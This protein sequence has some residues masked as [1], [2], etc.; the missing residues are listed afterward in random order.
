MSDFLAGIIS[1]R[2]IVSGAKTQ[3]SASL[4]A[5][6]SLGAVAGANPST[7]VPPGTGTGNVAGSNAPT[8]EWD[9]LYNDLATEDNAKWEMGD[10]NG[11]VSV[12]DTNELS[13]DWDLTLERTEDG[14][15]PVESSYQ[16]ETFGFTLEDDKWL[17]EDYQPRPDEQTWLAEHGDASINIIE[18]SVG[19]EGSV[20]HGEWGS[21][22]N[23]LEV[24]V[25]GGSVGADG[26]VSYNL[27]DGFVAEGSLNAEVY[28]VNA[29]Y[30]GSYGP[31]YVAVEASIGA[32]AEVSGQIEFDPLGGSVNA[33]VGA[34][35]FAGGKIEAE[36]GVRG[37]Y[38]EANVNAG[39]TYGVGA[40]FNA[41]VGLEDGVVS[42]EFDIGA[43]LGLGVDLGFE[44]E[45]DGGAVVGFVGDNAGD[46]IGFVG[47]QA[48]DA[49][50]FVGDVG[51]G[52]GNAAE[53]IISYRPW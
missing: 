4:N 33:G 31:G 5:N 35:A 32:E 53:S 1:A 29:S 10:G 3:L 20:L 25:L 34:E 36:T 15:T 46:A 14:W 18:G 38:G 24:D 51:G 27:E 2:Q 28:L 39:L 16:Q 49:I 26:S 23:K 11:S 48:G 40:E 19:V 52:I 7:A 42:A 30:E 43:T 21:E 6:G 45:V 50:G 41:E 8:N 37:E 47:D 9:F 22:N 13:T 44:V 12:V 17:A